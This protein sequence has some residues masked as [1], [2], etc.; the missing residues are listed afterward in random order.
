MKHALFQKISKRVH[1]GKKRD[2]SLPYCA[3]GFAHKIR[4][5]TVALKR[6][7][8]PHY[9]VRSKISDSSLPHINCLTT[10]TYSPSDRN[11][12][13][14]RRRLGTY[15]KADWSRMLVKCS[16]MKLNLVNP[17]PQKSLNGR[18]RTHHHIW[19]SSSDVETTANGIVT[20]I[21]VGSW[22]LPCKSGRSYHSRCIDSCRL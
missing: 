12:T 19:C 1:R 4:V 9:S 11:A 7:E 10:F 8:F 17:V 15:C 20:C 22:S 21:L 14:I 18:N 13:T 2:E 5:G 3:L 16:T 6:N